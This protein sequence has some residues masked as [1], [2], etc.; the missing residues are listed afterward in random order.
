LALLFV[1]SIKYDKLRF[2]ENNEMH[3]RL[4]THYLYNYYMLY[5]KIDEA[6]LESQNFSVIKD[7]AK[8]IQI[9]HFFKDK[10]KYKKY[11]VDHYQFQRVVLINNDRFKLILSNKNR[12]RFPLKRIV[13]FIIVFVL[14]IAMYFWVIKSLQPLSELKNKIKKFSKGDLNIECKSD[15]KDEIAEVA[16][17]FDDAVKMIR[18][19]IQSRQLFLRAIMH[20]LKTPIG[21]GRL[22]SEML[23]DEKSK[24]RLNKVFERLNMLIDEFAKIEKITSNNY[25]LNPKPYKVS[26]ILEASIDM[27][28]ID[29]PTRYICLDIKQDYILTV[30]FE[31]F[32]LVLKN[33]I[34]NAIKYSSDKK[35]HIHIDQQHITISNTGYKLKG[36]INDYYKPF[37]HTQGGLG[38]GIYIVKHILDMHNM[39]L[40]YLHKDGVNSFTI[41]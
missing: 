5:G 30:D 1:G 35:V 33:L 9:E 25:E 40:V 8:I 2:E 19:L 17:E 31:L 15:K 23:S 39:K 12:A 21:K 36:D 10:G 4:V 3:E 41:L 29:N 28:L 24:Q 14:I 13:V 20:E 38:L 26:D 6:Y 27:L 16:N 32:A 11:A 7:K 34:D 18:E 37:H 22:I